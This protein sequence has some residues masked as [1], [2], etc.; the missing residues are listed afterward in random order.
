[1]IRNFSS[2]I[3]YENDI[4]EV[5]YCLINEKLKKSKISKFSIVRMKDLIKE[6]EKDDVWILSRQSMLNVKYL[7]YTFQMENI[8]ILSKKNIVP[9]L[10]YSLLLVNNNLN[11]ENIMNI[12]Q[13]NEKRPTDEISLLKLNLNDS[14]LNDPNECSHTDI[15]NQAIYTKPK[16]EIRHNKTRSSTINLNTTAIKYNNNSIREINSTF[17]SKQN[18]DP[19]CCID[20]SITK[21][22]FEN[23][24]PSKSKKN[25][26]IPR[27]GADKAKPMFLSKSPKKSSPK[28][29]SHNYLLLNKIIS[30][31]EMFL[32]DL[33]NM[34]DSLKKVNFDLYRGEMSS[35]KTKISD[36]SG[37]ASKH[38]SSTFNTFKYNSSANTKNSIT[39][40]GNNLSGV[41][42][43]D[44]ETFDKSGTIHSELT[45]ETFC[46]AFFV[47]G[48]PKKDP[49]LISNSEEYR[50]PCNHKDCSLLASYHPEILFKYQKSNSSSN[51]V[52]EISN[53]T[54][55]LCFPSG[56]KICYSMDESTIKPI[57]TFLNVI[58][59]QKGD[60]FYMI[61]YH[62]YN[63]VD[64][65]YFQNEFNYD[66]IKIF[67]KNYFE[68]KSSVEVKGDKKL[69]TCLKW[70]NNDYIYIP[71]CLTLITKYPYRFQ[72]EACLDT[73]FNI[74]TKY[75]KNNNDSSNSVFN[76]LEELNR[77]I[78][79]FVDEIP[80]P[81]L[82][83]KLIFYVPFQYG[84]L[85]LPSV[86][87]GNAPITQHNL[88]NL[89]D[90]F[91]IE[92]IILIFY[93]ILLE[94][95]ILFIDDDYSKLSE[96]SLS[97]ISLIQPL[98]WENNLVPVLSE[99]FIKYLL[100][101]VPFIMG[102]EE[103]LLKAAYKMR[104]IL[105]EDEDNVIFLVNIR[106]NTIDRSTNKKNKKLN[107]K[108][109]IEGLPDLPEEIYNHLYSD[110]KS[111]KKI[112]DDPKNR[113]NLNPEKI[114]NTIQDVFMKVMVMLIGDYNSYLTEASGDIPA[115][116][117]ALY[118]NSRPKV[119]QPFYKELI[120]SQIFIQFLMNEKKGAGSY[121]FKMC[122][123]YHN[124]IN[125]S[126][127]SSSDRS[128]LN[129]S[130]SISKEKLVHDDVNLNTDPNRSCTLIDNQKCFNFS[131]II[132]T[133][134]GTYTEIEKRMASCQSFSLANENTA[135]NT[136][137]LAD[138][139]M[140][141]PYFVN[142]PFTKFDLN[143]I[144]ELMN[145]KYKINNLTND[146]DVRVVSTNSKNLFENIN[147][148]SDNYVRK[149]LINTINY[150]PCLNIM[151]CSY[152]I[153]NSSKTD[154]TKSGNYIL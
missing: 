83:K 121:F 26:D 5:S 114:N 137:E 9:N 134:Y 42:V 142:D 71:E 153:T 149:Y 91:S 131:N 41:E 150:T 122:A 33:D 89:L 97:F 76:P 34:P 53:V 39:L 104:Y 2:D 154:H 32:K 80:V 57:K 132:N 25:F 6:E 113:N 144:E 94:Q 47:S 12:A 82:S 95:K 52:F 50:S 108:N 23:E 138:Y 123:K 60:K 22:P 117:N 84:P 19:K 59:N 86:Q 58:T 14:I 20:N 31:D 3:D 49:K 74:M 64:Y 141:T 1:M 129:R 79:H 45:Y 103:I 127:K 88:R 107:K 38:Y 72:L 110:L 75:E 143:K 146:K 112:I 56:I 13:I 98:A 92:N 126:K 102:I 40:N 100:S 62:Y 68:S 17:D 55:G 18:D 48:L 135:S 51:H 46:E 125:I 27:I 43:I 4:L 133:K 81:P 69:Q 78:H 90:T 44:Y 109:L 139:I 119:N 61:N 66:P 29:Y 124:L 21:I 99:E 77:L 130:S 63:K 37:Y 152:N 145:E 101:I 120:Q 136:K 8:K 7:V 70:A 148:I 11:E 28:K 140:I 36:G 65:I 116:N 87:N 16:L 105:P 24:S 30:A 111:I 93:L 128:K 147:E 73:V 115:F 118:V 106:K 151:S 96:I 67:I 35:S 85:E 54:A 15:N 10:D